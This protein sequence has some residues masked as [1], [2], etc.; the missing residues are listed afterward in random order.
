MRTLYYFLLLLPIFAMAQITGKVI[1]VTDGDT[2][3]VL[4]E[5]FTEYVVRVADVDC[6][7]KSQPFWSRAKWFT[8]NEI[9]GKSVRI[10]PKDPTQAKDRYG[11]IIG[12]ILYNKKNLSHELLKAGLAWHYKYYSNDSLMAQIEQEAKDQKIGLWSDP[13]PINPYLWRK[14]KRN[15]NDQQNEN[16]AE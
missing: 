10:E 8:S 4:D 14:T 1:G 5:N 15:E 11:R 16:K 9:F 12:Y 13:N 6:P 2:V 7:E 3:K